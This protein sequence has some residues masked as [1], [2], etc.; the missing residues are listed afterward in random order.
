MKSGNEEQLKAFRNVQASLAV[1]GM[2]VPDSFFE[3]FVRMENGEMSHE[4]YLEFA[5]EFAKA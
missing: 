5:K 3:M 4:E 2:E 1:E